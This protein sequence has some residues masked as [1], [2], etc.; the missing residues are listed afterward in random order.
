M[1]GEKLVKKAL[2]RS[3]LN[4]EYLSMIVCRAAFSSS[5]ALMEFSKD[6][7]SSIAVFL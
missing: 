6:V 1:K 5:S 3:L 7:F 2:L 4:L